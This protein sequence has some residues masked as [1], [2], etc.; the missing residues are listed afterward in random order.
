[1]LLELNLEM[2]RTQEVLMI[3]YYLR[4]TAHNEVTL[5]DGALKLSDDI[6]KHTNN[7]RFGENLKTAYIFFKMLIVSQLNT[8]Y[9]LKKLQLKAAWKILDNQIRGSWKRRNQLRK[10][11]DYKLCPAKYKMGPDLF[12]A[13]YHR[14]SLITGIIF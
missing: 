13:I 9:L 11:L 14:L 3:I 4:L 6:E 2:V 12:S 1:M 8:I 5:S 10:H 7:Q